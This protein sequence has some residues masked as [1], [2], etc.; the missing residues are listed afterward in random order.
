MLPGAAYPNLRVLLRSL[1]NP[2]MNQN[3]QA[4]NT[5]NPIDPL[6]EW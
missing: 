3:P 5:D 4:E 6:L 2:F 1:D